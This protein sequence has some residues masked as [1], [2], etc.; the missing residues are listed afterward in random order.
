M[1]ILQNRSGDHVRIGS[2]NNHEECYIDSH[3]K[4]FSKYSDLKGYRPIDDDNN[5]I[6]LDSKKLTDSLKS[7]YNDG[8]V[9]GIE[10]TFKIF[11]LYDHPV[12]LQLNHFEIEGCDECECGYL[13]I[14]A[15]SVVLGRYNRTTKG[16]LKQRICGTDVPINLKFDDQGSGSPHVLVHLHT[17]KTSSVKKMEL[18]YSTMYLS[19]M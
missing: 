2:L 16:N 10:C 17:N 14:Y 8:N 19:G 15:P 13:D 4:S 6:N 5:V 9:T 1:D 12:K 3:D 11:G 18:R 7:Y